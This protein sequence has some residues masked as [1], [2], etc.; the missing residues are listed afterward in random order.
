MIHRPTATD[1]LADEV[2]HPG[3]ERSLTRRKGRAAA[4]VLLAFMWVLSGCG[5]PQQSEG[6]PLCDALAAQ[7]PGIDEI[8]W[9]NGL[10]RQQAT[11]GTLLDSGIL[12][13]DEAT[14]RAAAVAV[15]ADTKG[16][17]RVMDAAP[18]SL[19]PDLE[20]LRSLLLDPD[21]IEEGRDDVDINEAVQAVVRASPPDVCG[22]M[23]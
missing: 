17:D 4:S 14:R 12:E 20:L 5:G 7:V 2:T 21:A 16:F 1:S 10:T 18:G 9:E 13:S 11:W 8:A 23:R 15:Q 6:S 19:R 22:W 3:T